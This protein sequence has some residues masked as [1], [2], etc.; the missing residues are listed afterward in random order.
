MSVIK[1]VLPNGTIETIPVNPIKSGLDEI[2]QNLPGGVYT[3]L[4][5]YKKTKA[6]ALENHFDRLEESAHLLG[7]DIRL[8]RLFLRQVLRG[9][10]IDLPFPETRFRLVVDCFFEP[11][12]VFIFGEKLITPSIKD[13]EEGVAAV[14]QAGGRLNPEAKA[15]SFIPLAKTIR[16]QDKNHATN[17]TLLFDQNGHILEGLSSNFFGIIWGRIYTAVS[18]VLHGITRAQVLKIIEKEQIPFIPEA[19]CIES[20]P[21]LEE[22]FITSTSRGVL[23]VVRI[24]EFSIGDGKPGLLTKQI[25]CLFNFEIEK[26]IE[27]I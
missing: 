24:G 10:V 19:I 11:G 3:T 5:T 13:Y 8:D 7:A 4:R 26:I 12:T 20:V 23:P 9:A 17:E 14:L 22:A 2:T 15:T 6:V 21:S 16:K 27:E 25:N 1:K 18:G